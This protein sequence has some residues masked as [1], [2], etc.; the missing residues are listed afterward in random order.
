[1]QR[2]HFTAGYTLYNCVCDKNTIL[3]LKKNVSTVLLV[4]G[5]KQCESVLGS[6]DAIRAGTLKGTEFSTQPLYLMSSYS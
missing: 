5:L 3:L 1:M 6:T 4:L 2:T